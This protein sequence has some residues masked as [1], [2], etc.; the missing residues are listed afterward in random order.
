MAIT[1]PVMVPLSPQHRGEDQ[2][3]WIGVAKYFQCEGC[4]GVILFS[5]VLYGVP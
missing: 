4:E 3:C 5:A 1:A 2:G